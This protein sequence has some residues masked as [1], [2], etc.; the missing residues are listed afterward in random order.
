MAMQLPSGRVLCEQCGDDYERIGAHWSLA[1][2]CSFPELDNPTKEILVGLLMGDG[3]IGNKNEKH[4]HIRVGMV[5]EP[6][7]E[8]LDVEFGWLSTGVREIKSAEE[9]YIETVESGFSPNANVE[10]YHDV[11]GFQTRSH[12]FITELTGWYNSG[13]KVWPKNIDLTP[14]VLLI[15]Y[16]CDG[17]FDTSSGNRQIKISL[18]NEREN[19]DKI[20]SYFVR[21]DAPRPLSWNITPPL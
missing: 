3:F 7:L 13:T 9:S 1:Y 6:F 8:W 2:D 21:V 18:A 20:E 5:V 10:D 16:V 12:P 11:F 15:L 14:T 4:Q 17:C 19:K